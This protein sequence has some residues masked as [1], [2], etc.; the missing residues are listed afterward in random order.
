MCPSDDKRT[1]S[2]AYA[3]RGR[4]GIYLSRREYDDVDWAEWN[5]LVAASKS[6]LRSSTVG[7]MERL[8]PDRWLNDEIID[9][10]GLLCLS[11]LRPPIR[12]RVRIISTLFWQ[13]L[14]ND[15]GKQ[16]HWKAML[17]KRVGGP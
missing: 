5:G 8:R 9:A 11:A 4:R 14:C 17:R 1:V 2:W 3:A 16:Q 15:K 10:Y 6:F 12:E 13:G 7:D